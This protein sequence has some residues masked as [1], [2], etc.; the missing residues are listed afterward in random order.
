MSKKPVIKWISAA[1]L[2]IYQVHPI[3]ASYP[4]PS[5]EMRDRLGRDML[6]N[7]QLQPIV[8][9]G[10]WL[11]DGI[12]RRDAGLHHGL[13][14]FQVKI[15]ADMPEEEMVKMISSLNN[16]RRNMQPWK[17]AEMALNYVFARR[18][19]GREI[20]LAEGAR[21]FGVSIRTVHRCNDRR[22]KRVLGK[23][24]GRAAKPRTPDELAD[25]QILLPYMSALKKSETGKFVYGRFLAMLREITDELLSRPELAEA[26]AECQRRRRD[27]LLG[28]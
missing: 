18:N 21:M 3:A 15:H 24:A 10:K 6:E 20:T 25:L 11:I 14:Q 27:S 16:Q 5:A 9:C 4:R 19:D 12:S 28:P 13:D 7:G 2:A 23:K 22:Q 26:Y 8:L 1:E 17:K